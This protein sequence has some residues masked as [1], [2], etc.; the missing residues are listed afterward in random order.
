MRTFYEIETAP[1]TARDTGPRSA[2]FL[3]LSVLA[4]WTPCAGVDLCLLWRGWGAPGAASFVFW[5]LFRQAL[6]FLALW[7]TVS[8][9]H[10][11]MVGRRA[12]AEA[13]RRRTRRKAVVV[14]GGSL[15]TSRYNRGQ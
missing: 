12:P 7:F 13:R 2:L 11:M 6:V 8:L 5:L 3:Q 10:G 4:F 1:E 9:T 15:T 14:K